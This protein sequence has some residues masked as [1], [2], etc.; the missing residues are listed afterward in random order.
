MESRF[1]HDFSRVRVHS[2]T[3]AD[4]S[5]RT[6]QARAYTVGTDIV[7]RAGEYSPDSTDGQQ[8]LAHELTHVI[9]QGATAAGAGA[10]AQM[11][12]GEPGDAAE[13]EAEAVAR[14]VMDGRAVR[15]SGGGIQRAVIQREGM[16][17][18]EDEELPA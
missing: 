1:G 18:E 6:V 12:V 15:R 10:Q 14:D 16:P 2:D 11:E 5:A 8:L 7:F 3:R 4:E 9:Q 17:E 13:V